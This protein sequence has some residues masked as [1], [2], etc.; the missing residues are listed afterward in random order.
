MEINKIL[1]VDDEAE[2]RKLISDTLKAENF[3][4]VS[5]DRGKK[6]LEILDETVDLVILDI[7]MPEMNGIET[8]E[9]IRE[10]SDVP[11]IFLTAKSAEHVRCEGFDV[12]ADDFLSKPFS[13]RELV[14]R[15]KA[16]LRRTGSLKEKSNIVTVGELE[17][18]KSELTVKQEGKLIPLTDSEYRVLL[19]LAENP[20]RIFSSQ[21]I[22]ESIWNEIYDDSVKS[23]ISTHISNIRK[24]LWQ[25]SKEVEYIKNRVRQGYYI[26]K[27]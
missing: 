11:V 26:E 27:K 14:G 20:N 10:K 19:L 18:N 12:G 5:A 25:N 17:I 7:M 9:K 2:I 1:V 8:C 13:C 24:K 23:I 3:Q 22:Y 16:I 21:M 6:A 4:V 15:I